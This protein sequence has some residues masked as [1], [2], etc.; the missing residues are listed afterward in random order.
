MYE[1][2]A[3]SGFWYIQ[4]ECEASITMTGQNILS[5]QKMNCPSCGIPLSLQHLQDAIKHLSAFQ[6]CIQRATAEQ[7]E[8]PYWKKITPPG[9][10]KPDLLVSCPLGG[11][12]TVSTIKRD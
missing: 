8:I 5:T 11:K 10:D 7:G 3:K 4:C 2:D 6:L 1:A 12:I 9:L